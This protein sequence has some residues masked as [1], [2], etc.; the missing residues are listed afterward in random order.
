MFKLMLIACVI[1]MTFTVTGYSQSNVAYVKQL[2]SIESSTRVIS[3]YYT[4]FTDA[5]F[6]SNDEMKKS[7]IY[8]FRIN[9]F[10]NCGAYMSKIVDQFLHAREVACPSMMGSRYLLIEFD[11][12]SF[13][14]DINYLKWGNI[15]V[16]NSK[17]FYNKQSIN[18][19]VPS[20]QLFDALLDNEHTGQ[21]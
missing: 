3:M 9:C 1:A 16:F 5:S 20:S 19:V 7:A 14:T 21:R 17:C 6:D 8:T 13:K 18:N 15:I 11:G 10:L 2:K 12:D 4:P